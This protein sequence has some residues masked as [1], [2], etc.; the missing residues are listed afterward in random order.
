MKL[1]TKELKA[2]LADCQQG[3]KWVSYDQVKSLLRVMRRQETQPMWLAREICGYGALMCT[4]PHIT[5][6]IEKDGHA[7]S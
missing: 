3:E 2:K 7:H 5:I 4:F 6:G 1:M